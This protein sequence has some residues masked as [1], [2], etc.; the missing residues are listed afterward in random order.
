MPRTRKSE[1]LDEINVTADE[2]TVQKP[3]RRG[4]KS[5]AQ[6]EAET[7]ALESGA[8]DAVTEE[9]P[10]RRPGRPKKVIMESLVSG[11]EK[12][13]AEVGE[14]IQDA[15]AEAPK[16]RRGRPAGKAAQITEEE[17]PKKRRGRKSKA[18][19]EAEAAQAQADH[20]EDAAQELSAEEITAEETEASVQEEA[21]SLADAD[22][23][24][25]SKELDSEE[26][27]KKNELR[28]SRRK[29]DAPIYIQS[30]LGG[31]ITVEEVVSR[32]RAA[33][34]NYESIYIKPEDNKAYFVV[35]G[36]TGYISLW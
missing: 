34:P 16:K 4:R 6:S 17:A 19:I 12:A 9:K 27:T 33:A 22:S 30:I 15:E 31:E 10:K 23:N 2:E 25:D 5:K 28:K 11:L 20:A 26:N 35:E 29:N 18:M 8:S 1:A 7:A 14:K 32:V 3:K 21:A 36:I 24:A 13:V